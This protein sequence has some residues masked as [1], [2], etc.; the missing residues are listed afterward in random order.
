MKERKIRRESPKD[1]WCDI[2]YRQCYSK[3]NLSAEQL[4]CPQ[5]PD[6]INFI[7]KSSN[8]LDQNSIK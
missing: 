1:M 3:G 7:V 6:Y 8:K 2:G 5:C 4:D